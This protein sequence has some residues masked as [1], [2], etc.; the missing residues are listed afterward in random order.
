MNVIGHPANLDGRHFMLPRDSAKV[1]PEPLLKVR[2]D[3]RTVFFSAKNTVVVRADVGHM[4]AFS[5]P[6]GTDAIVKS[7]YPTLKG[8]AIIESSLR[9]EDQNP[10]GIGRGR[11]ADSRLGDGAPVAVVSCARARRQPQFTRAEFSFD[12][13]AAAERFDVKWNRTS[14][15][16]LR[17]SSVRNGCNLLVQ[18]IA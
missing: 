14:G 17:S 2:R 10:G 3:Q 7:P 1:R 5:R 13:R 16:L 11:P 12:A 18:L 4:H 8:W 15:L 6:F 9:D